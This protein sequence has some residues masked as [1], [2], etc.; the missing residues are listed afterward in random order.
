MPNV[1]SLFKRSKFQFKGRMVVFLR[2][3]V[4]HLASAGLVLFD[5]TLKQHIS[6][7]HDLQYNFCCTVVYR[8]MPL[9]FVLYQSC[10]NTLIVTK[11]S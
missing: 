11:S 9:A 2:A 1:E 4:V 3:I 6:N 10:L 8:V 7:W 5:I